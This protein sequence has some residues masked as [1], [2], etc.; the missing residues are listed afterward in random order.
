MDLF[1]VYQERKL[2]EIIAQVMKVLETSA[3]PKF[4]Y[5]FAKTIFFK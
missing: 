5:D 4:W 2:Y 3:M 1:H